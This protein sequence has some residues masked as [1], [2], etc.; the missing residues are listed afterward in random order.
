MRDKIL[1]LMIAIHLCGCQEPTEREETVAIVKAM[2]V[3][4][5]LNIRT[6]PFPG[7][8]RAENRVNLSFRVSGPLLELPIRVG[9][10]MKKGDTLAR[11]DPRDFEVRVRNATANLEKSKAALK[12]AESDLDRAE[13]IQEADPGAI[14]VSLVDQKRESRNRLV[15][16]VDALNAELE[17]TKDKLR[18]TVLKAPFDGIIVAKY[19]ENF[20]FVREREPVVRMLDT[21]RIEMVIDVP[22]TLTPYLFDVDEITVVMDAFPKHSLKATIKEIGT[23]ASTTTRTFPVTLIMDHPEGI[24]ILAGMTGEAVITKRIKKDEKPLPVIIPIASTF[25]K[26]AMDNTFVWVI[27]PQ[28]KTVSKRQ[29]VLGEA[30]ST[31][32]QVKEGLEPGEWIVTAGVQFLKEGQQ[33]QLLKS[34]QEVN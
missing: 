31:G 20:E 26:Q 25:S 7:V 13:R 23:E 10:V 17:A 19:L 2:E 30:S 27:D 1:L 9:D 34:K 3:N 21:T 8:I 18:D 24:N 12:F 22:E 15:A 28:T 6:R 4:D 16:S 32:V 33:V 11:I 14:S 5:P 29:V